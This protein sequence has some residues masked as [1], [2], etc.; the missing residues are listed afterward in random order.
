MWIG[1]VQ[2]HIESDD[3]FLTIFVGYETVHILR[4]SLNV[5]SPHHVTVIR[6]DVIIHLLVTE[7]NLTHT[8]TA[9]AKDD[10]HHGSIIRFLQPFIRIL[11][12]TSCQV[13][14]HPFGN[15]LRFIHR[16]HLASLAYL[17]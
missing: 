12:T 16:L 15:A 7:R 13:L 8:V 6:T 2:M 3:V 4:P 14:F 1:F 11:Y 5:L 9:T 10:I 17:K